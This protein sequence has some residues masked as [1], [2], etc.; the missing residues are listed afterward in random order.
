MVSVCVGT[1]R[2]SDRVKFIIESMG[3]NMQLLSIDWDY[4][5]RE[6]SGGNEVLLFDWGH[7]E[8][9][10]FINDLWDI[11]ASAFV[12]R[13]LPLPMTTGDDVGFWDQFQFAKNAKLYLSESHAFAATRDLSNRFHGKSK[14]PH[15]IWSFDAHHDLGYD[16]RAIRSIFRGETYC[17]DWLL[18]YAMTTDAQIHVR[19]PSWKTWAFEA[20]P[21]Y[22]PGVRGK[23]LTVERQIVDASNTQA[24][25]VFDAVFLCRS[26]AW[27]PSWCDPAF[28]AF[29]FDCPVDATITIGPVDLTQ[30]PFNEDAA[31]MM[32]E[33]WKKLRTE[34]LDVSTALPVES[35]NG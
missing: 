15:S 3:A 14:G 10:F 33:D 32:G 12:Q 8:N 11:R 20:E 34:N 35:G 13:K 31:R 22:A 28:F 7:K 18:F 26:G 19:Y 21:D 25:P 30:R 23:T 1:A 6:P 29:V 5:F 16:E 17:G 9:L 24:M 2:E 27:V 4:F